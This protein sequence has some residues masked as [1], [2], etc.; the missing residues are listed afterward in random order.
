MEEIIL[1]RHGRHTDTAEEKPHALSPS[2]SID[3]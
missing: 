1:V 3:T 2:N